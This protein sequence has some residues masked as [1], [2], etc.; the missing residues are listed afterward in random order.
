MSREQFESVSFYLLLSG[1]QSRQDDD[2]SSWLERTQKGPIL[3][4][5]DPN[6]HKLTNKDMPF[7]IY[8]YVITHTHI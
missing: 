3:K 2:S 1:A 7:Y 8:I 6:H 4:I 5:K